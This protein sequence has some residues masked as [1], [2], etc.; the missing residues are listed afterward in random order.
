MAKLDQMIKKS[1]QQ[2]SSM[3]VNTFN[4]LEKHNEVK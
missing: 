2:V 4:S 3:Y 1:S